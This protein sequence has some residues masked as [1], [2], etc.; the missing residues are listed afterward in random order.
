MNLKLKNKKIVIT[1]ASKGIGFEIAKSFSKLGSSTF[2]NSRDV[3]N[4]RRAKKIIEDKSLNIFPGDL[5]NISQTKKFYE[6]VKKNTS[7]IDALICNIGYSTPNNII[8]EENYEN[9]V[10]S[11]HLNLLSAINSIYYFKK[12]LK[13][14]KTP[15]IVCISSIC[16]VDALGAPI[17]YS[18]SKAAL[19][20]FVK[21]QAKI[22]AKN[23]IRINSVS[24][25]NIIFKNGNWDNKIKKDKKKVMNYIKDNVPL[26]RFGTTKNIAD[27]VLFLSSELS[28]FTTGA[29]IIVDG[30]Q[31]R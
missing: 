21:N 1:G 18:V 5:T 12:L 15:S 17:D 31:T 26:N 11:I 30:G 20:S 2:I 24:P 8:G 3:K 14:S 4:L 19:I 13:K 29:N 27:I 9:W 23:N 25:G 10:N 16:G 22:L 6:F 28:S 7:V